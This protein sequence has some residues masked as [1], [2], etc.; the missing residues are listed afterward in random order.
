MPTNGTETFDRIIGAAMRQTLRL[1]GR[2]LRELSS[3]KVSG[4]RGRR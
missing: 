2:V 3:A 4:N 1:S